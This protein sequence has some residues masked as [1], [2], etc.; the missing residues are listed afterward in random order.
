MHACID[1]FNLCRPLLLQ[2]LVD[3]FALKPAD[4]TNP[5]LKKMMQ[6]A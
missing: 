5:D 3:G 1:R 6:K 2:V 4:T